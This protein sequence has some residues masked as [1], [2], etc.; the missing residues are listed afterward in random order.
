MALLVRMLKQKAVYW[1]PHKKTLHGEDTYHLPVEIRCRWEEGATEGFPFEGK[2]TVYTTHVYMPRA[3]PPEI[4]GMLKQC[5]LEDLDSSIP[6]DDAHRIL[7]VE[8]IPNLKVKHWLHLA[9]F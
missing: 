5:L 4:G 1:A 7:M 3:Y 2:E 9:K 6:P 8:I